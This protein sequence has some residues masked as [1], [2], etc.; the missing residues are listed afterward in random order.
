MLHA[1]VAFRNNSIHFK[2]LDVN[3][4]STLSGL[5]A[6]KLLYTSVQDFYCAPQ[7]Y[8]FEDLDI[9]TIV[10]GQIYYI[11]YSNDP[12]QFSGDLLIVLKRSVLLRLQ[13]KRTSLINLQLPWRLLTVFLM[14]LKV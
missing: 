4:N 8:Q 3:T 7:A 2:S 14:H 13:N 12:K 11:R 1:L 9:G 6:Y 5:L 10:G